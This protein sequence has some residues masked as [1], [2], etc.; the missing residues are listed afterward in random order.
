[1]SKITCHELKYIPED[2]KQIE[3]V[4]N[5][6]NQ[7]LFSDVIQLMIKQPLLWHNLLKNV[8]I[9]TENAGNFMEWP[10]LTHLSLKNPFHAVFLPSNELAFTIPNPKAFNMDNQEKVIVIKNLSRDTMLV[11]PDLNSSKNF[12]H[13]T[14]FMI[15]VDE[16]EDKELIEQYWKAVGETIKTEIE[17]NGKNGTWVSTSG[18]GIPWLHMRISQSPKYYHYKEYME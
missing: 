1:M 8:I 7:L 16:R 10:K 5:K 9:N 12:A 11:I 17:K 14:T 4:T 18:L 3:F 2:G 6:G 15:E 13:L